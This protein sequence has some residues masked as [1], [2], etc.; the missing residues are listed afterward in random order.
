[1]LPPTTPLTHFFLSL[2]QVEKRLK[3]E[4]AE[5][6]ST[7]TP[8]Q[9]QTSPIYLYCD[10]QPSTISTLQDSETPRAFLSDSPPSNGPCHPEPA[11][12]VEDEEE[13][14]GIENLIQ[15]L[16]LSEWIQVEPKSDGLGFRSGDGE[17]TCC[18]EDGFYSRIAGV[19]GPTCNKEVERLEG[20]VKHLYSGGEEGREPLRL[21]HLLLGKAVSDSG[22][23]NGGDLGGLEFPSTIQDFLHNDPPPR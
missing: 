3:S 14:D 9:S 11:I 17:G 16:G 4:S 15:L 5:L 20:W 13:T 23:G 19:K 18:C 8:T 10:E 2:K 22:N 21:A 7:S 12:G 1:M 6:E